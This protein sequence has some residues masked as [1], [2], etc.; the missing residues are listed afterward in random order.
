MNNA[1]HERTKLLIET[2]LA[3]YAVQPG[4]RRFRTVRMRLRRVSMGMAVHIV[5]VAVSVAMNDFRFFLV[6]GRNR[7][8]RAEEADD[9]HH[10]EDNQHQSYS[11]LHGQPDSSRNHNIKKNND[12]A[13]NQNRQSMA[14]APE[15]A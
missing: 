14:N 10:P 2:D 15:N 4:Q 6:P 13:D 8:R 11:E 3:K 1:D 9:I 5:S 7:I 12:G